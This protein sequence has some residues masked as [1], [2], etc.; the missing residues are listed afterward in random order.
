MDRE[1]MNVAIMGAGAVGC[2]FGGMLARSGVSVTLIG[3]SRN[4]EAIVRNG[5]LLRSVHFNQRIPLVSSIDPAAA[6]GASIVLFC[7][8]CFDTARAAESLA[9]YVDRNATVISLQNG[10]DNVRLIKEKIHSRVFPS[11]VYV[12]ANMLE[13][14]TVEHTGGGT[15]IIGEPDETQRIE[16]QPMLERIAGLMAGAEVQ[17]HISQCIDAD[18]WTK[19][20]MNCAYNAVS[21]LGKAKYKQLLAISEIKEIMREA[22]MEAK[23]TGEAAGIRIPSN[24]VEEALSCGVRAP[25]ATSS[26]A[27]DIVLGKRTEIDFLNGYICLKASE[28]G[29]SVPVNRTI[30]ALMKLLESTSAQSV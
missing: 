6:S 22:V 7:V 3:R 27:Q 1:N 18:M 29:I 26:T 10:V 9:P 25:E 28:L 5:L 16:R 13:A 17:C 24:A 4:I 11:V 12:A 15:L 8:K 20:M 19:L 23:R 21:A 30:T 2:Y 14:G